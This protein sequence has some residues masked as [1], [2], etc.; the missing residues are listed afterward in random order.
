MNLF[1]LSFFTVHPLVR[2]TPVLRLFLGVVRLAY[3]H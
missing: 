1:G 3:F 2:V